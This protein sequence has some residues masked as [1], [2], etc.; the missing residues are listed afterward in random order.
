MLE[1]L[2]LHN[3][4][5]FRDATIPLAPLTVIVGPNSA[6]KSSLVSALL[7]LK[8]TLEDPAYGVRVPILRLAG[9]QIDAGSYRDISH[10]HNMRGRIEFS[11]AFSPD[12]NRFGTPIAE[13]NVPRFTRARLRVL[14]SAYSYSHYGHIENRATLPESIVLQYKSSGEFGPA[15]SYLK[16]EARQD[17]SIWFTRTEEK[18][19]IQHWRGYTNGLPRQAFSLEFAENSPLFPMVRRRRSNR[20]AKKDQRRVAAVARQVNAGFAELSLLLRSLSY[21]GPFRTPPKRRYAFSGIGA[22]ETGHSGEQTTDLLIL[23]SL[24]RPMGER[25]LTQGV[26]YWLRELGLARALETSSLAAGSNLFEVRLDK[27]GTARRANI[28]DVGF[29][30]SQILPV[31]SAGLLVPRGGLFIVQQP[32]LHLHPDAQ[33]G[34]ADYFLYLAGQGVRCVVETHSEYLLVRLRRR[35]AE[36][37][38]PK[39]ISN[40]ATK[41]ILGQVKR[42]DALDEFRAWRPLR[43]SDVGVVL[44][45]VGTDKSEVRRLPINSLFQLENLPPDFMSRA[46]QDRLAIAQ[47]L[48]GK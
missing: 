43:R 4:R 23:E 39:S 33:A 22:T 21:I 34:L 13:L 40:G 36:G 6:G 2:S 18:E 1:S 32:E 28:A 14:R 47:A 17:Q 48:R 45:E 8:Q 41:S 44:V 10:N 24:T 12:A 20:L 29:G 38:M 5:A 16:V 11:F 3:Y 35:L 26:A 30:L 42:R 7:L 37:G 9:S 31:L 27:A 25:P 15:L 19:R 46:L